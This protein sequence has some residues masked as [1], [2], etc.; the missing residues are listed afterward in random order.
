MQSAVQSAVQSM[1]LSEHIALQ[2]ASL[3][4]CRQQLLDSARRT[5]TLSAAC[6]E[7]RQT[8]GRTEKNWENP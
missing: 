2:A 6:D 4:L 1:R 3:S 8:Y 5:V 7:L